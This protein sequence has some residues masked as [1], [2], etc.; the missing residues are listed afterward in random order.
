MRPAASLR[1]LGVLLMFFSA[2]MLVPLAVS[3]YYRDGEYLTF[4]LGFLIVLVSGASIWF[5]ARNNRRDLRIRDGFLITSL[6]WLGLGV[7]GSVPFFIAHSELDLS[8]S[9]ALFESISG[10]TTTGAT[11]ITSLDHLPRWRNW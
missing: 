9:E 3:L 5:P 1:V 8:P 6:F 11:V 10:L 7:A 4:G 2:T